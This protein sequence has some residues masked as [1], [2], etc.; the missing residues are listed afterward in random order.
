MK[1]FSNEKYARQCLVKASLPTNIIK[2]F[3]LFLM[4]HNKSYVKCQQ[5][6]NSQ[7]FSLKNK[8][9]T[10]DE[11]AVKCAERLLRRVCSPFPPP[12]A[13]PPP[14]W[15]SISRPSCC[16]RTLH[17]T[18]IKGRTEKR[19]GRTKWGRHQRPI[20]STVSTCCNIPVVTA[21]KP[22]HK[23]PAQILPAGRAH[24]KAFCSPG[25]VYWSAA[26]TAWQHEGG[27]NGGQSE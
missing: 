5:F 21:D 11:C 25:F 4:S 9:V 3:F 17:R 13:P 23:Q 10:L 26:R 18:P 1:S 2:L 7:R 8:K 24:S 16:W 27:E 12:P 22:L 19:S 14:A 6:D 20:L 15:V